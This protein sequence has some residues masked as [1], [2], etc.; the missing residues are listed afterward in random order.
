MTG[1]TNK[2]T[3]PDKGLNEKERKYLEIAQ[4]LNDILSETCDADAITNRMGAVLRPILP[5]IIGERIYL[6]FHSVGLAHDKRAISQIIVS[7]TGDDRFT[8]HVSGEKTKPYTSQ[9]AIGHKN[10]IEHPH[11]FFS[12]SGNINLVYFRNLFTKVK[13]EVAW[14]EDGKVIY[15]GVID[16]PIPLRISK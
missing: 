2:F 14:S 5:N 4:K 11:A 3:L 1:Y 9:V 15:E 13:R 12:E 6:E 16:K 10:A 8:F 7:G